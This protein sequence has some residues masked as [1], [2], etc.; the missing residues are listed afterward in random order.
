MGG[1]RSGADPAVTSPQGGEREHGTGMPTGYCL[2]HRGTGLPVDRLKC[3]EETKTNRKHETTFPLPA[4]DTVL[5]PREVGSPLAAPHRATR[6]FSRPFPLRPTC[7]FPKTE[8][9]RSPYSTW[10]VPRGDPRWP[11]R[12]RLLSDH[13][14]SVVQLPHANK[15][16]KQTG[17]VFTGCGPDPPA[18]PGGRGWLKTPSL[19]PAPGAWHS[20]SEFLAEA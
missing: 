14:S 19:N 13:H 9:E 20:R 17:L 4:K 10:F 15:W 2:L 8:P 1:G 5:T 7:A 12:L 3:L 18:L 6:V 11:R 16:R